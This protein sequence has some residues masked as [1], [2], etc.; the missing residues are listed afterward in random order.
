MLTSPSTTEALRISMPPFSSTSGGT[1]RAS[2][3]R[4]VMRSP[5]ADGLRRLHHFGHVRQRELLEVGS[6]GHGHV[7]AGH[8][9]HGGIEVVEC[10]FHDAHGN[11]EI[12]RAHV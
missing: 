4:S 1:L 5:V 6:V 9:G 2:N 7:L 11:L 3:F 10:V 8:A 12:G